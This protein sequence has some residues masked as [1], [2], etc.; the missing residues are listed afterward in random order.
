MSMYFVH[1]NLSTYS[2]NIFKSVFLIKKESIND[3]NRISDDHIWIKLK[4]DSI[5]FFL[6]VD[7]I[8]NPVVV[9]YHTH[10]FTLP[11]DSPER[12]DYFLNNA[13]DKN[14]I[15][16]VTTEYPYYFT[17]KSLNDFHFPELKVIHRL[18]L[19]LFDEL[20][21]SGSDINKYSPKVSFQIKLRLEKSSVYQLIRKKYNFYKVLFEWKVDNIQS[22]EGDVKAFYNVYLD[23]IIKDEIAKIIPDQ[24]FS[25]GNWFQNPEKEMEH[26][27]QSNLK[28][29]IDKT[30]EKNMQNFFL[31]KHA[32]LNAWSLLGTG[33][34]WIFFI[35][36]ASTFLSFL[37]VWV[38]WFS[39]DYLNTDLLLLFGVSTFSIS[40]GILL[41]ENINLI[42]PRIL[43]A[44]TLVLYAIVGSEVILKN[45]LF[46]DQNLIKVLALCGLILLYYFIYFECRQHSKYY[47]AFHWKG[48]YQ[49]KIIPVLAYS[50][51]SAVLLVILSHLFVTATFIEN[52]NTMYNNK[53]IENFNKLDSVR[54]QYVSYKETIVKARE[55]C[56]FS[57]FLITGQ[58]ITN[59]KLV[60]A[61]LRIRHIA[62]L[63]E[64]EFN[65][66]LINQNIYK[67]NNLRKELMI[68][69]SLLIKDIT[70][71][72]LWKKF[73]SL[74]NFNNSE[75]QKKTILNYENIRAVID[76][77]SIDFSRL[78]SAYSTC[79]IVSN[80]LDKT[81]KEFKNQKSLESLLTY[82]KNKKENKSNLPDYGFHYDQKH[83]YILKTFF[84]KNIYPKMLMLQVIIIMLVGLI[85]QLIISD[86]TVTEPL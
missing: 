55:Q 4:D 52:S 63:K 11:L 78:N 6:V 41:R 64:E 16:S 18:L 81:Y 65:K 47:Q 15:L 70:S 31:K 23:V 17:Q 40:F 28:Y 62:S 67:Y 61:T 8:D 56:A 26:L 76:S 73:S 75:K 59:A 66:E 13:F 44:M 24:N 45:Q 33:W 20:N 21:N 60:D 68:S 37:L 27:V 1:N 84:D 39:N 9:H 72:E 30:S 34:K 46:V 71:R 53:F 2:D 36:Q 10:L 74:Q 5:E 58:D 32:A 83:V 7:Q 38:S 12:T 57:I 54:Y 43:I 3:E 29:S 22:K 80:S 77:L 82:T 79:T 48:L 69:D 86:K 19:C 42:L 85:G 25:S 51:N 49:F 50:F 35:L 14:Y